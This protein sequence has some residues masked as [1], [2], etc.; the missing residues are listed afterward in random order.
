MKRFPLYM[1]FNKI[2]QWLWL[3]YGGAGTLFWG[4]GGIGILIDDGMAELGTVLIAFAMAAFYGWLFSRGLRRRRLA[5]VYRICRE[6]LPAK[7]YTT[8]AELAQITAIQPD[9][10][11]QALRKLIRRKLL[12][13]YQ[14]NEGTGELILLCGATPPVVRET[15][16]VQELPVMPELPAMPEMPIAAIEESREMIGKTC[17][18]CGGTTQI[19]RGG[20]GLCDYCGSPLEDD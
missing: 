15:P 7:P 9:K 16:V 3:L 19:P 10:L 1:I 13:G 6:I 14:F 17:P 20:Y 4:L 11:R 2:L 12:P 5:K 18:S 8:V